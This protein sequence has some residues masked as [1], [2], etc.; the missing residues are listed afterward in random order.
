MD[1]IVKKLKLNNPYPEEKFFNTIF[2]KSYTKFDPEML[3]DTT[4]FYLK[5]FVFIV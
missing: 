5:M 2:I 1:S 3:C 4:L